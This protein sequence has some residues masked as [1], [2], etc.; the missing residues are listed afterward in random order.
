MTLLTLSGPYDAIHVGAAAPT[1]PA[2][3]VEQL[4]CPGRMFIPVG[5]HSQY[6][7]QV[8]KDAEGEVTQKEVMGVS[9]RLH[10]RGIASQPRFKSV[11]ANNHAVCSADGSR[12]RGFL[13]M[14]S[15][16]KYGERYVLTETCV[17]QQLYDYLYCKLAQFQ[18]AFVFRSHPWISGFA[19]QVSISV[20]LIRTLHQIHELYPLIHLNL[21]IDSRYYLV[22]YLTRLL[23]LSRLSNTAFYLPSNRRSCASF[24][25]D[26]G[27]Q[28]RRGLRTDTP[29]CVV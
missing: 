3:L 5:T 21:A 25:V 28:G 9:V 10:F 16:V 26:A 2:A 23:Q 22:I 6:I 7:F 29:K 18:R 17:F 27:A 8:D 12:G 1:M 13:R 15:L 4:A 11:I 24:C 20:D 14:S 19:I